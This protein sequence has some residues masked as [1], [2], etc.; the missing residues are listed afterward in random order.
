VLLHED[1]VEP[2]RAVDARI[3]ARL[4]DPDD[5]VVVEPFAV[6]ERDGVAPHRLGQPA[7]L[8]VAQQPQSGARPQSQ[9]ALAVLV[10]D[11]VAAEAHEDEVFGDQPV[12]E[13]LDLPGAG[14]AARDEAAGE[15][16]V[17][18]E[19]ADRPDHV[20]VVVRDV[21]HVA[22]R[23]LEPGAKRL[24]ILVKGDGR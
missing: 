6:F 17:G 10:V 1:A 11:G 14:G 2:A 15:L 5:A 16:D 4:L 21:H 8:L 20:V 13:A 7:R 23:R 12:Q 19:F 24:A 22:E 9:H 3:V 18:L